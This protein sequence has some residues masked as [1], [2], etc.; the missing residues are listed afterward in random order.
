MTAHTFD[1]QDIHCQGCE[2]A[3]RKAL[4]RLD[5]VRDASADSVSNQ[6]MVH[7]DGSQTST[8]AIADRLATAGYP[9]IG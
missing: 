9:V 1:V 4:T 5:G 8:E 3:I 7:Y 2:G 6:V